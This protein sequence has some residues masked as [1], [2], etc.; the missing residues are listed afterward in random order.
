[1][2]RDFPQKTSDSMKPHTLMQQNIDLII[3]DVVA[4][5]R[6]FHSHPELMFDVHRTAG[7]VASLLQQMGC[8]DVVTGIGRTGV[9]GVIKGKSQ[10]SGRVIGL[11]ADMDALPIH[12]LTNVPY[13]SQTDGKMHACGHD[14]HTSML[15]GAARYL[16]ETRHFDGTAIVIFQPAEE[17]GGGGLEMVRDGL[18]ERFGIQEVYGLHNM[19]GVPVGEFAIRSGPIM[20]SADQFSIVVQGRGGHA[21]RPQDSIDPVLVSAHIITALQ[22][23]VG[24][25]VDPLESG[26]V[27]LTCVKA[28]DAYN[29]IPQ[30]ASLMGTCR[31]L[32]P[33]MREMLEERVRHIAVNTA[34]TF[35]AT[36][37]VHYKRGYPVTVN[38]EHETHFA[39]DVAKAVVGNDKVNTN[40]APS[41]G[42]EDF[43]FMLEAR[44]G[45]YIIMGNGD[46]AGLHHPAYDFNDAAIP[47]G[48]AY[49]CTLI[50]KGMP[51]V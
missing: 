32:T 2:E 48:I 31:A 33:A 25:N 21:A 50:E 3:P 12:E 29:V 30:T 24:R 26:V 18:M 6:D 27:S 5:R 37:E 7:K 49:W 28:G 14:G 51:L 40:V 15:L 1:L 39:A 43:S 4:W 8:D 46:T 35:G 13:R 19:P 42:A 20:A 10:S 41:M 47:Y 23:I 22:S 36:A 11:R 17:G 9:V 34:L 45:A 16:C 38:H 44:K